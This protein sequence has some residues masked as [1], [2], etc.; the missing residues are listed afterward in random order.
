ME[1]SSQAQEEKKIG[2]WQNSRVVCLCRI[3]LE[4]S[5]AAS[6]EISEKIGLLAG[7][8]AHHCIC[9]NASVH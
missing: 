2:R 6:R 5:I 3:L 4:T 1:S 8:I 9:Q 7:K